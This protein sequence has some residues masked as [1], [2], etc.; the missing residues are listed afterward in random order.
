[1]AITK[2]ATNARITKAFIDHNTV[3]RNN[4]SNIKY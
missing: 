4:P 3:F 2:A 1:M